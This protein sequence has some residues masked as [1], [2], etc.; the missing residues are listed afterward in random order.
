MHKKLISVVIPAYNEEKTIIA[1]IKETIKV[2]NN[3][4]EL[5]CELIIVDDGSVDNTCD[6]VKQF[7]HRSSYNIKIESYF[8]N[9]GKGFALKKGALSARGDYILFMDADLEIHPD[10]LLTFLNLLKHSK[11]DA[12]IGSKIARGSVVKVP[13][14]RKIISS[15]Y[16]FLLK[17]LFRLPVTDTQTG[18]KLFKSQALKGCIQKTSI[19]GYSFDLELMVI[20]NFHKYKIIESPIKVDELRS[21]RISMIDSLP[22][23]KDTFVVFKRYYFTRSYI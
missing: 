13:L 21:R 2:I 12:V 19:N 23:L 15:G 3:I 11:A 1:T 9:E 14:K 8:P 17:L 18:F 20:M 7:A 22:M 16:Y 6:V 4:K 10:H 5:N